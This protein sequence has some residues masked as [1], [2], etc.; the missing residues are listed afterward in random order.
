M[1]SACPTE[2]FEPA[3]LKKAMQSSQSKAWRRALGDEF[4]S[5]LD[6]G[7]WTSCDPPEGRTPLDAKWVFKIKRGANGEVLRHKA[8]LVVRG[9]R[10]QEGND[11]NETFASVVK[12]MSYKALFAIAAANDFEI[13]QMTSKLPSYTAR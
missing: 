6:N 3:N 11:F 1:A 9:F 10:Q 2:P 12:P 7:T 13:E 8:R 4:Q 5:L